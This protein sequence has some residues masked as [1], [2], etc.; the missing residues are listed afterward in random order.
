MKQET[1]VVRAGRDK[2]HYRGSVN[3]PVYHVSTVLFDSN[4]VVGSQGV[5]RAD[6]NNI[7]VVTTGGKG[8]NKKLEVCNAAAMAAA[9]EGN[10]AQPNPPSSSASA[11]A[12]T[13]LVGVPQRP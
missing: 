4:N 12:R 11:S 5:F 6:F 3:P 2:G 7:N 9:P 10:K 13:K 1:R 8:G